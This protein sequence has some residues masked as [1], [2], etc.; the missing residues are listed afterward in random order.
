MSDTP[1]S[2]DRIEVKQVGSNEIEVTRTTQ[3]PEGVELFDT[4]Y[5]CISRLQNEHSKLPER[6][7]KR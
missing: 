4:W 1:E 6:P 5:L 7:R 3:L 2:R